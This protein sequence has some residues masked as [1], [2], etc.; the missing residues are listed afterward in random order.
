M[1]YSVVG[2]SLNEL[3]EIYNSITEDYT[4]KVQR[5]DDI[6]EYTLS[7]VKE[8]FE[9]VEKDL[10]N[11]SNKKI[12]YIKLRIFSYDSYKNFKANLEELEKNNIDSLIID[13]RDNCGGENSNMQK[14]ASLF[15]KKGTPIHVEKSKKKKKTYYSNGKGDRNYPILLLGNDMS[16]SCS[17]ILIMA[18]MEGYN[19]KFLGTNTY[20][21]SCG[22]LVFKT[23][24]YYYKVTNSVWTSPSGK[25]V[26]NNGIEPDI[27]VEDENLQLK[28][29]KEYLAGL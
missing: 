22:Q 13:L 1:E 4:I 12:G 8:K 28:T 20:G 16:A 18:L 3:K 21:K 5:R 29:A 6:Y 27:Y 15:L 23:R 24:N 10:F 25:S 19:A 9:N 11:V 7:I 26:E 17:E 2:K 14:I